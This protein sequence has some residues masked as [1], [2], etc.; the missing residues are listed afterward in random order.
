MFK[1]RMMR[2]GGE[3]GKHP[4]VGTNKV[5]RD[6][7]VGITFL[8][9]FG[10]LMLRI[11][12]KICDFFSI[13][14]IYQALLI[15]SFANIGKI[16]FRA[17]EAMFTFSAL[18]GDFA[19]Y[20]LG[21]LASALFSAD[22][23]DLRCHEALMPKMPPKKGKSK[24]PAKTKVVSGSKFQTLKVNERISI[25]SLVERLKLKFATGRGFYQLTK[26]ETI[27][28]HK[29]IVVRRKSDGSMASG[30]KVNWRKYCDIFST[31][32]YS[33]FLLCDGIRFIGGNNLLLKAPE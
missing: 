13:T 17:I 11:Y 7:E 21:T 2:I 12:D 26:A 20:C 22:S 31:N 10:C 6:G 32:Y 3:N 28:F 4:L 19:N 16:N 33:Y 25:K 5:T 23:T 18:P 27:Q 1:N 14:D 29:E 30:D 8:L 9:I 24:V 15:I